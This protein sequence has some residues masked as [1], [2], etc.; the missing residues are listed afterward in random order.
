MIIGNK[1]K[2]AVKATEAQESSVKLPSA[3]L[4]IKNS[5]DENAATSSPRSRPPITVDATAVAAAASSPSS[6]KGGV[7][8]THGPSPAAS[9]DFF[10][11]DP[12]SGGFVP[13]F[14]DAGR[15]PRASAARGS[16]GASTS[17]GDGQRNANSA[18]VPSPTASAD[19]LD[20]ESSFA[21]SI[22]EAGRQPA[23]ASSSS[24]TATATASMPQR[25]IY[26]HH[27]PS[28]AA[29][30]D[31]FDDDDD[32]G[33]ISSFSSSYLEADR[34]PRAPS[35]PALSAAAVAAAPQKGQK[36]HGPSPAVSADQN[37][38]D[39]GLGGF[40]PSFLEAGRQPRARRL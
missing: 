20:E 6:L 32:D 38:E 25:N 22:F 12:S 17:A 36:H 29:S 2:K 28:P 10:D 19:L 24:A 33:G 7:Y 18:H 31:L 9:V 39:A 4:G 37:D 3:K 5:I 15:K 16:T 23:R 27:G 40:V 13:S 14:L 21:P 11:D 30:A 26:N 1:T 34:P 8:K 35:I